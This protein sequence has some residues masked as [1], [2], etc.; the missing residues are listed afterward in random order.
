MRQLHG[1]RQ[2]R[3]GPLFILLLCLGFFLPQ[4]VTAHT[5]HPSTLFKQA[6]V[7]E[8]QLLRSSK[9]KMYRDRWKQCIQL[10]QRA[11]KRTTSPRLKE[12]AQYHLADLNLGLA[13]YS[14]RRDDSKRARRIVQDFKNNFPQNRHGGAL[15]TPLSKQGKGVSSTQVKK[16]RYGSHPEYSRVVFDLSSPAIYHHS[17]RANS[18]RILIELKNAHLA[19]SG[20]KSVS[21]RDGII[22]QVKTIQKTSRTVH[23]VIDLDKTSHYRVTTLQNPH[24]LIVD[25]FDRKEPRM[26]KKPQN[27]RMFRIILDPGHGGKDPGAVGPNRLKESE[28]VLDI[29]RMLKKR[30]RAHPDVQVLMTR[31]QNITV[32]LKN[33]TQFA[34]QKEGDLFLSIHA[35]A[36][37]NRRTSGVE[38]YT[39][40]KTTDPN[41]IHTA[42]RE[43]DNMSKIQKIRNRSRPS[44]S[45]RKKITRQ[46]GKLATSMNRSFVKV[47][48]KSYK[49]T[50]L[51]IKRAPFFV[52]TNVSMPSILVEVS[53]ISNPLEAK[54]LASAKYRQ[55]IADSL[56]E[57]IQNY[58]D[59]A[60]PG[61]V[62]SSL[63]S[64]Q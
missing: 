47:L 3:P 19:P 58:R 5:S 55:R 24:R 54:R 18:N 13:R 28:V 45:S 9:A 48:G 10:Y 64:A 62:V 46:S 41:T 17:K 16:V 31:N 1:G 34:N 60:L 12:E 23:A 20:V 36:S 6:K 37:P 21:I 39:L 50:N 51:G 56:Y 52:L 59:H 32:P 30:L 53:F 44:I 15:E 38:I 33:R 29:A 27:S 7:C 11:L 25:I 42:R 14:G 40:G 26:A 61:L 35:N 43:N 2:K 22:K 63:K 57:G 4:T 8:K 49:T